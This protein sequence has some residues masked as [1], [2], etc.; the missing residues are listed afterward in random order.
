M[1]CL[2]CDA[3]LQALDHPV[4]GHPAQV[5]VLHGD[6]DGQLA[7]GPAVSA[8]SRQLVLMVDMPPQ[9]ASRKRRRAA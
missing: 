6:E 1:G 5:V 4:L 9:P 8:P 2:G 3:W 7:R